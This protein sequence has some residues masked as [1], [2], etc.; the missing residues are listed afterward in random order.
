[1]KEAINNKKQGKNAILHLLELIEGANKE[2]TISKEMNSP[3]MIKQAQYL[4]MKYTKDLL[5][6]LKPYQLPVKLE[7]A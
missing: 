2:I 6:L 1:M 7:A 5:E 3:L 4:K